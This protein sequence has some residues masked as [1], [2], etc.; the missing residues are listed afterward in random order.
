MQKKKHCTRTWANHHNPY[1]AIVWWN[2]K[3][4]TNSHHYLFLLREEAGF[5]K[6][7]S[8]W[9]Q[10]LQNNKWEQKETRLD[11][12]NKRIW[13][14]ITWEILSLKILAD[15]YTKKPANQC[16]W[17]LQKRWY[18]V[19]E[20]IIFTSISVNVRDISNDFFKLIET[21]VRMEYSS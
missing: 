20:N 5:F 2:D 15:S 7:Q 13:S 8:Y 12:T 10:N 16:I 4:Y 18:N 21:K 14:F 11:A 9:P 19:Y 17:Q 3:M 6:K 1:N